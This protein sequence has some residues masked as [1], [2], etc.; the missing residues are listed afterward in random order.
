MNAVITAH[1]NER[2][3][4]QY[5]NAFICPGKREYAYVQLSLGK[6]LGSLLLISLTSTTNFYYHS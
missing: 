1:F 4:N 2:A 5:Y 3:E 6:S